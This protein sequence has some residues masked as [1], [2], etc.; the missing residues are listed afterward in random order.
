[1]GNAL[2]FYGPGSTYEPVVSPVSSGV[3]PD[4]FI[5]GTP[6][7]M[8]SII[9]S[10]SVIPPFSTTAGAVA[11]IKDLRLVSSVIYYHN[12]QSAVNC[13]GELETCYLPD[14]YLYTDTFSYTG[15]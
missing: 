5:S 14:K 3:L 10:A 8:S 6:M 4:Q 1:M 9:A 11:N 7:S 12:T 15:L 2:V 13:Q